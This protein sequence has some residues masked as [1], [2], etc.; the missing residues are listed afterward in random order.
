M[1][2]FDLMQKYKDKI[3]SNL[4]TALLEQSEQIIK[5]IRCIQ[6]DEFRKCANTLK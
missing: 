1:S 2:A 4:Q 5:Q 6:L 3:N